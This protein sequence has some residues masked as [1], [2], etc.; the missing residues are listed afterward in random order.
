MFAMALLAWS[1]GSVHA[2]GAE[3]PVKVGFIDVDAGAQPQRRTLNTSSTFPVYD[4]TAT[5]TSNHRIRNGGV[6][7]VRGGYRAWRGLVLGAGFTTFGRSGTSTVKASVPDPLF[8]DRPRTVDSGGSDLEHREQALHLHASWFLPVNERMGVGLS[9]GPSFVRVTQA[10]TSTVTVATGTQN[11]T[12]TPQT[13]KG[14]AIGINA[15]ID[16][17]YMFTPR[18]GAGLFVRY[19]VGSVDLPSAPDFTVGGFQTGL[20]LRVRF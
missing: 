9:A 3:Y 4:E 12:V 1:A 19:V 7:G 13:E 14:T 8:S 5:V 16:G 2:Q 18:Y 20:G 11:V 10:L 17:T 6:F 15:G